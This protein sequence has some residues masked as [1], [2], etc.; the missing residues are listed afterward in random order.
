V[1]RVGLARAALRAS[2]AA[3]GGVK[4]CAFGR[5]VSFGCVGG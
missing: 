3:A 2:K 4:E 5:G 1:S